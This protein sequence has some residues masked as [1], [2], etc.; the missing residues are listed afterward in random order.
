[1]RGNYIESHLQVTR[2]GGDRV[3]N[4]WIEKST[5]AA[6]SVCDDLR[7]QAVDNTPDSH[8]IACPSNNTVPTN[9]IPIQHIFDFCRLLHFD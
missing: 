9:Y 8:Q 2:R 6:T 7:E 1:V 5:A 4:V 3:R